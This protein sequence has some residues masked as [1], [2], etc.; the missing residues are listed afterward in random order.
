VNFKFEILAGWEQC[1]GGVPLRRVPTNF[2]SEI[3]LVQRA[4]GIVTIIISLPCG[5]Y[6]DGEEVVRS[7]T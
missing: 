6:G 7:H 4:A 5:K 1:A 2:L 3:Y